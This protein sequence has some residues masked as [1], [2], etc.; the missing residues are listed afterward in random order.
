[1]LMITNASQQQPT[2]KTNEHRPIIEYVMQDLRKRAEV[3]KERYGTYLQ[4]NNGRDA[5]LDAYE[6]ALD[7]TMYLKQEIIERQIMK[8][9]IRLFGI[10]IA[11][12]FVLAISFVVM[13]FLKG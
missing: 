7:Q 2:P 11:G 9:R 3:G 12:I 5:L 1:M 13:Q 8:E 10:S 6:E 4:P